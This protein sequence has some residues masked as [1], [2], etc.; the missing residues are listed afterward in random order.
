MSVEYWPHSLL[1]NSIFRV[2]QLTHDEYHNIQFPE[3]SMRITISL[4]SDKVPSFSK[5]LN[6]CG[7]YSL[8][9]N[10]HSTFFF[11]NDHKCD[12]SHLFSE[13]VD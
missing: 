2:N 4:T 9:N 7:T 8:R 1:D 10:Q 13:P 5:Q 12:K 11:N 6:N 3:I